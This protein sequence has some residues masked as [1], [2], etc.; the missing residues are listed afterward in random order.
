MSTHSYFCSRHVFNVVSTAILSISLILSAMSTFVFNSR[1]KIHVSAL[2]N[3][4]LSLPSPINS[5]KSSCTQ[6]VKA[7]KK[8]K[9]P[10]VE[11]VLILCSSR[12]SSSSLLISLKISVVS[13]P[14]SA[15]ICSRPK[16][17]A[18]TPLKYQSLKA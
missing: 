10:S 4:F 3:R 14:L 1:A 6:L 17:I 12:C 16:R 9:T 13:A 7:S 5:P 2:T 11:S 18:L 8:S 15:S